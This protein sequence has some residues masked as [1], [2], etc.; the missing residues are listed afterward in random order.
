MRLDEKKLQDEKIYEK[1]E[2]MKKKKRGKKKQIKTHDHMT[3]WMWHLRDN[4]HES[5]YIV[6][7]QPWDENRILRWS[8]CRKTTRKHTT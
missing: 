1:I 2:K 3:L 6:G 8:E 7:A 4:L 5:V